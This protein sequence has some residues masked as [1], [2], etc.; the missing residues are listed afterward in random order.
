MEVMN[1]SDQIIQVLDD[2]CRRFGIAIDWT[3]ENVVPYLTALGTKLV[4]FEIWTSVAWLVIMT[5]T[6]L[7]GVIIIKKH[8]LVSSLIDSLEEISIVVFVC[9]FFIFGACICGVIDQIMDII[10]CVTFPELFIFEYL[11]NML[12]S[13]T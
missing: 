1:A 10:K 13:G 8:Q 4:S 3:S 9:L 2:I 11:K 12:S 6:L 5:V 7:A